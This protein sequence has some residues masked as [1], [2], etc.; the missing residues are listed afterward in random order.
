MAEKLGDFAM[1]SHCPQAI[2]TEEQ[3]IM[4]VEWERHSVRFDGSLPAQVTLK[5]LTIG[6]LARLLFVQISLRHE[7]AYRGMIPGDLLKARRCAVEVGAAIAHVGD[8]GHASSE[9]AGGDGRAHFPLALLLQRCVV[10]IESNIGGAD[11]LF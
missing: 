4:V 8:R 2:G 10:P 1:W 7:S 5:H 6:M 3:H 11:A 9:E